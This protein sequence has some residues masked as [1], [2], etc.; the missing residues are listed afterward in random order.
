MLHLKWSNEMN[1]KFEMIFKV[2]EV[3]INMVEIWT[4][5]N[6]LMAVAH[7]DVFAGDLLDKLRE[8]EVIHCRL[9]II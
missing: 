4:K 1:N 7:I 8:D 3:D 6:E 2:N 5:N 9:E